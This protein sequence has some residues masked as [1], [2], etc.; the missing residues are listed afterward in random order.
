MNRTVADGIVV[1]QN[2]FGILWGGGAYCKCPLNEN[3]N[4]VNTDMLP[5]MTF[6]F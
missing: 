6:R 5:L 1:M 4:N 2:K 3:S